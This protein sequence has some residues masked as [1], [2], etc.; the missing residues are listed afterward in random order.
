MLTQKIESFI[1]DS[2]I[3]H[4]EINCTLREAFNAI[5]EG[6]KG[7]VLLV[8]GKVPKGIIT[9]RD[10][11]DLL[12]KNVDLEKPAINY[13]T[14]RL[15]Q[16]RPDRIL[17]YAIDLMIENNI[18]RLLI[19]DE[20]EILGVLTLEDILFKL[21]VDTYGES[22]KVAEIL[23]ERKLI[24]VD[25]QTSL[26]KALEL[27][28]DNRIGAL[29]VLENSRAV[30]IITERDIVNKVNLNNLDIPVKECMTSPVICVSPLEKIS[31]CVEIM[32]IHGIRR[33]LVVDENQT[34]IGIVSYRD[35]F[36]SFRTT[37]WNFKK[38]SP[39]KRVLDL[40][41]EIFIEVVDNYQ[42]Q[43]VLWANKKAWETFGNIV[44]KNITQIIPEK[45]WGWI[46][47]KLSKE[48]HIQGFRFKK[49][50][51]ILELSASY[52]SSDENVYKGRYSIF[53]RDVSKE[54]EDIKGITKE[55]DTYKRIINSTD[56]LIILYSALDYKINMANISA[57]K[58]LGYTEEEIKNM[59]IFD[60][61]HP[62]YHQIVRSNIEKIIRQDINVR[63]RRI[64]LD[65]Y[66]NL[67]YVDI[68]ATKVELSDHV[69]ILVVARDV[70][71][72]IK[73]EEELQ[74]KT[75]EL[76]FLHNFVISLNRCSSE[77]EAYN[78]LAKALLEKIG[79]HRLVIYQIN[80]SL[81]DIQNVIVYGDSQYQQCIEDNIHECKVILGGRPL[82]VN[83]QMFGCPLMKIQ[84]GSYACFNLTSSGK[85]IA[86]LHV[87]AQEENF[88][89][90]ERYK[91]IESLVD[92][93]SP[94]LSNLRLIEM[95]K[96]LSIRDPLTNLYNRRYLI[97]F[98]EKELERSKRLGDKLSI[99]MIDIDNFKKIN[100]LYG[101]VIGDEAL[102]L[103]AKVILENIRSM[104]IAGR[105]GGEEFLII[106]P[107]TNRENSIS[108]AERIRLELK[109]K[110]VHLPF[111]LTA[112]FGIATL[113]EDGEDTD[114]LLRIAD[115]RLYNAKREGK[116]R[117]V[118]S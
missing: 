53:M 16:C 93:F 59:T 96:E 83:N 102:K 27:M 62:N 104:D 81:N 64:Y 56:D 18:R 84:Q 111:H 108:I 98:F 100:D 75:E 38:Y 114:T 40:L 45:D 43:V 30:G 58:R 66:S 65:A 68:V 91:F 15:I 55:L 42:E 95:N 90:D 80:P 44:D 52:M 61:I 86:I 41:P 105:Y 46:H 50:E 11:V 78:I 92:S 72:K 8:D 13:A 23:S 17:H 19:G 69:Y 25:P 26:R 37:R 20:S 31:K 101:H 79:I 28:K 115:E 9:E 82:V 97:E 109:R 39:F 5:K 74:K 87:Y 88:F 103:F 10:K 110:S 112:S 107:N 73:M 94:F 99:I 60:I 3:V 2:N 118:Y 24:Y 33:L 47:Y 14:K 106:L 22:L 54:E 34:P 12:T 113:F 63:G 21:S 36:K 7:Y 71:E 117:I 29:P 70:T 89:S 67:V 77:G 51:H 116:D 35:I 32:K 48:E 85:T 4:K 1:K 49:N 57:L 76:G 6:G